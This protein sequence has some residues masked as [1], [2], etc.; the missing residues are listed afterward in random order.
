MQKAQCID[1]QIPVAYHIRNALRQEKG[2]DSP[3]ATL[4]GTQCRRNVVFP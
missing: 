1:G 2:G 4:Q 3:S